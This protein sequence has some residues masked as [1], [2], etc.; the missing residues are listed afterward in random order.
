[1]PKI[2]SELVQGLEDWFE[3]TPPEELKSE[4][5]RLERFNKFGPEVVISD[6]D[7]DK[8]NNLNYKSMKIIFDIDGQTD[9]KEPYVKNCEITFDKG[10]VSSGRMGKIAVME[11]V[12]DQLKHEQ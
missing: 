6:S 11:Y 7:K 12:L 3:Q 4:L 1:M 8:Q 2:K 5:D 9:P 10:D